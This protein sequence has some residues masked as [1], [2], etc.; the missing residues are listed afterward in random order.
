LHH[1]QY[2]NDGKSFVIQFF[3]ENNLIINKENKNDA[4]FKQ[5][6]KV[7]DHKNQS[8]QIKTQLLM[9][10]EVNVHHFVFIFLVLSIL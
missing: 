10:P 6:L 4:C 5:T 7:L 3:F 1:G 8:F 2:N 9:P